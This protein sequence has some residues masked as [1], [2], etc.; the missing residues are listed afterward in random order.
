MCPLNT[1]ENSAPLTLGQLT[2]CCLKI[3][4]RQQCARPH[5]SFRTDTPRGAQVGEGAFVTY[6]TWALGM[7]MTTALHKTEPIDFTYFFRLILRI[8]N[9]RAWW[10]GSMGK[11]SFCGKRCDHHIQYSNIVRDASVQPTDIRHLISCLRIAP[12]GALLLPGQ[13]ADIDN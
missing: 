5:L 10:L 6:T 12:V 8:W 3:A 4:E 1:R 13:A 2:L 9:T 7:K 11:Q